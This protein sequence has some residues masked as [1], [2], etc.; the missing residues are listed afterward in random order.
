MELPLE[1]VR[2]VHCGRLGL[3]GRGNC[4]GRFYR[5]PRDLRA[6]RPWLPA[7]RTGSDHSALAEESSTLVESQSFHR[8]N[9]GGIP[10]IRHRSS[11]PTGSV[12][13]K[14]VTEVSGF[15]TA[16]IINLLHEVIRAE[17]G[18]QILGFHTILGRSSFS[19]SSIGTAM[20]SLC[21]HAERCPLPGCNFTPR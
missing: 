9:P 7:G 5:F 19:R 12:S 14:I 15:N 13:G 20:A 10:T 1:G 2:P 4:P 8:A 3:R 18:S 11:A 16:K 6:C 17:G 21:S